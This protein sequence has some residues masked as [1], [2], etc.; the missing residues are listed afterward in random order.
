MSSLIQRLLTAIVLIPLVV[1]LVLYAPANVFLITLALIFFA[2]GHEWSLLS[3]LTNPLHKFSYASLVL[4]ISGASLFLSAGIIDAAIEL[5][6]VFWVAVVFL[7]LLVPSFLLNLGRSRILMLSLG[8]CVLLVTWLALYKLRIVMDG[9]ASLLMYLLLLI[10]IADSGAY[11][12]GRAFGKHKLAPVIS[13]GKSIEGVVG[14]LLACSVFAY[15]AMEKV[16]YPSSNMFL[17]LSIVVAFVSVYG[18]LFE[19]LLKRRAQVKDSGSLL[20]GHGGILDRIDSLTA[21]APFFVGSL[22]LFNHLL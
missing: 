6:F 7:L 3:G 9:G 2:A 17:L 21:A 18:D 12:A 4:L 16:G 19:S 5:M 10:W 8:L 15:F 14:G 11:F 22:L 1:W 20:P 13:P